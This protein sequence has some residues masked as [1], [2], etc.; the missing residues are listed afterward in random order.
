MM[1]LKRM[2]RRFNGVI[3]VVVFHGQYINS[4]GIETSIGSIWSVGITWQ[5]EP[6]YAVV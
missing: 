1:A 5:I 2:W 4:T 6:M 3:S